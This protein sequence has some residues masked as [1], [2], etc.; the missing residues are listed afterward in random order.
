MRM[1]YGKVSG[2]SG[3][4]E[5]FDAA[6][7][8]IFARKSRLPLISSIFRW[9]FISKTNPAHTKPLSWLCVN[10]VIHQ[11]VYLFL[12]IVHSTIN[13]TCC[14]TCESIR[15]FGTSFTNH[16]ACETRADKTEFSRRLRV[17][18][19]AWK[20][21]DLTFLTGNL[22]FLH[23]THLLQQKYFYWWI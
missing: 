22:I 1:W 18:R 5:N 11:G 4:A 16:N 12:V 3:V 6:F 15:F 9:F 13:S 8:D 19:S 20:V 7:I 2:E 23:E 17:A 21:P 10:F 14:L